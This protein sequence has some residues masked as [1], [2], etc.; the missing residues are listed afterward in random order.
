MNNPVY[1]SLSNFIG[2]IITG[3]R[4]SFMDAGTVLIFIV[5][6]ILYPMLYSIGYVN[7]TIRDIPVAVIDQD[8]TSLS[9][10]YT[11]MLDATEQLR[12]SFKPQNL[13]EAEQ[14]FYE[15]KIHGIILIPG[16]FEKEILGRRQADVTVYCDA[17]K[18]FV[19]KQVFTASTY[20][21]STL[22]A[23]AEIKSLLAQGRSWDQA[24]NRYEGLNATFFDLYNPSSGYC[25][26]I[27]PGIL[28][29]VI[30]QSLLVGIGLL[31]GKHKERR[32][33]LPVAKEVQTWKDSIAQVLGKAS[34]YVVIYLVTTLVTLVLLYH[35]LSFPERGSFWLVY[36][37]LVPFLFAVSFMGIALSSWFSKRVHALMFMVFI[38]PVVF[39]LTGVAWPLESLPPVLKVLA[40]I[41]PTTPMVPAF[42]KLRL[43][44][45][46]ISSVSYELTVIT[47]QMAAYFI[48]AV[49]SYSLAIKAYSKRLAAETS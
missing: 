43:I 28:I 27:V 44:G 15:G 39:F 7:Q 48:L 24:L 42:I 37:M 36:L 38:S 40:W 33:F 47:I 2:I 19:Y 10:Q 34:S 13:A 35:W 5:A 31:F 11:R 29:I 4:E 6:V 49:V 41:F 20:A 30:Q 17:G 18:F 22:N 23:G 45:G 26:F 16:N 9:R 12:V 32:Q 3:I 21:T 25:T 8:H 1:N 46:G 14:L